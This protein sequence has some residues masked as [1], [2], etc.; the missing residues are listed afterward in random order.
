VCSDSQ[1][2]LSPRRSITMVTSSTPPPQTTSTSL[3]KTS[4]L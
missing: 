3:W 2:F 4:S 1:C